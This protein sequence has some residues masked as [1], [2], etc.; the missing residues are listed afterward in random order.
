MAWTH[1]IKSA[2]EIDFYFLGVVGNTSNLNIGAE[3]G[4]LKFQVT[5]SYT[6]RLCIKKGEKGE[7]EGEG[8]GGTEGGEKRERNGW[9]GVGRET[10]AMAVC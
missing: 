3:V 5:L 8:E 4:G 6:L 2:L 7:K 1:L 9:V 10:G